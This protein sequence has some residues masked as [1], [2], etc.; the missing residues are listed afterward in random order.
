MTDKGIVYFVG[1]GPGDPE[2]ITVKGQRLI[3]Q[4]D[5]ILYA[6]SLVPEDLLQGAPAHAECRSSLKM[7]LAQQVSLMAQ[8]V[9]AGKTVVRLHTGDPSIYG[10]IAEQMQALRQEG[11][12]YRVVPGVSSALAAA[13]AL[14]V[15]LTLPEQTQTVILTRLGGRTPVPESEN[16]A[17][18][19]AH[20][21]SL[22]IFLSTGMIDRVVNDLLAAGYTPQ[23]PVAVVYRVSWPDE[24]VIRGTL[25]DIVQTLSVAEITHHALIVVS[26]ALDQDQGEVSPVSHLYSSALDSSRRDNQVAIVALTRNGVKTG[27][28]LL[29]RLPDG[30]LYAPERFVPE[31]PADARIIPTITSIRQTLQS[32]FL[33]HRALVCIMASGIVV[34]EIASLLRAKH[35]D[36]AVVVMDEAGHYAISLISG[37]K[38]GANALA[39]QCAEI[40]GGQA[41][42]T[43]ASDTQGLPSLDLLAKQYGW[44][45]K[46]TRHLTAI[47]AAM[48]NGQPICIYQD[49]GELSWL[50][51]LED[52]P[53]Q[54]MDNF[55]KFAVSETEHRICITYRETAS[56]FDPSM[57]VLVF[58]P[59]CLHLGIGCNRDTPAE[60]IASAIKDT[61]RRHK[62]SLHSIA[63][64]ATIDIKADEKGILAL[65][66]GK[67]WPLRF[68]SKEDLSSV[69]AIPNPSDKAMECVGVAGVAEPAAVLSAGAKDWL[70]EKQKYPNV[71]VAVAL[72]KG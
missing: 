39:V 11:V 62:L 46:P 19:A 32:A 55:E 6:G 8:A 25:V 41:V 61:L 45:M 51:G 50:R 24:K 2:L 54:K 1:A 23:T 21:S 7:K 48:V 14:Q 31:V 4:A 57:S 38:G 69:E 15:E 71:T 35:V 60:E 44:Q 27:H 9:N 13:A 66:R 16:L 22:I 30:L 12:P 70:V 52:S 64:L 56:H 65:S 63:S 10:A 36:P 26:P 37:H 34:R 5:L 33:R 58:H 3:A 67:G 49:C 17:A 43:T 18:L 72:Q 28:C 42:V 20:H 40:L 47:S 29:Q 68:Y 53:F 59:P